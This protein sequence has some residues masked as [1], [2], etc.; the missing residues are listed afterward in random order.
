[1]LWYGTGFVWKR[2]GV[3]F[4]NHLLRRAVKAMIWSDGIE[5]SDYSQ[6]EEGENADRRTHR[7]F[8]DLLFGW[9]S[10]LNGVEF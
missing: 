6:D 4:D 2:E 9:N 7:G 5:N 8:L 10:I 3:E 1:M